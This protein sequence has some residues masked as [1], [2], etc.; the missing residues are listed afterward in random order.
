MSDDEPIAGQEPFRIV[1]TFTP[2]SPIC[3]GSPETTGSQAGY[4]FGC[5]TK[6]SPNGDRYEAQ[7]TPRQVRTL[8]TALLSGKRR[9]EDIRKSAPPWRTGPRAGQRP[10]IAL[11]SRLRARVLQRQ[12]AVE[13]A[14]AIEFVSSVLP[15]TLPDTTQDQFDTVGH[16]T[17]T[18]VAVGQRDS[19]TFLRLST[20]RN[21]V[22]HERQRIA[23]REAALDFARQK[24]RQESCERFLKWYED[25]RAQEVA[26]GDGSNAEKIE[27]LGRIMFG[28]EWEES[29]PEIPDATDFEPASDANGR[30]NEDT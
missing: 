2:R 26:A 6:P 25:R 1:E 23:Q 3:P 21:H 14:A 9:M 7:L 11:L 4:L 13:D 22:E 5:M 8:Q 15:D 28:D 24:L 19:Q 27:A 17:L 18:A 30:E 12:T 10:G 16:K 29:G 20:A